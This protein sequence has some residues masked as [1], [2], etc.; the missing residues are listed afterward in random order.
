MGS[1]SIQKNEQ[2]NFVL[3]LAG[4][5]ISVLMSSVY[6]F[7]IGLFVLKMTGSG[8]SF[9]ITL[10]L[11]IIPTVLIGPLA[12]V[13]ADK[14]NKKIMVLL[15][16]AFNGALFIVMFFASVRGLSLW[17]IYTA[18]LL[19]S[20]SQTLY[21]VCIDSAVPDIVSERNIM[22]LNS[23]GKIIDA[24]A[25]IVSPGL[26][27]ILFTAIDIRYFFLLNGFAFILSTGTECLI[28]FRLFINPV[29][30]DR[31]FNLRKDLTEG[32]SY[33]R[34]TDWL[35]NTL[36]NFLII[37]FFIALCYSV[38]IPYILNSIFHLPAKAYGIVQCF[39]PVGMIIGALLIKKISVIISNSKL[40]LI[41]G[42]LFSL[43]LFLFGLLPAFDIHLTE[44]F[45][46]L[47]YAFLMACSGMIVSLIDIPFINNLQTRVPENIRGRSLSI[48]ISAVKIFTPVGYILSGCIIGI[49]PAFY[50]PLCGG[51]FLLIVYFIRLHI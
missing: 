51:G 35:R 7:A 47:Y 13:L 6:T 12:G 10:S 2:F 41:N 37:N 16:D 1:M 42:I 49:V 48:S 31:K 40:L 39:T 11:Q 14:F 3:F 22:K 45:I 24:A 44:T 50:L 9:A 25:A 38:P 8:L 30:Q 36:L 21:N 29:P 4:R 27:G 15:T 33:I 26:G 17:N 34:E 18:T 20:V 19:L 28:D 46:I 23:A 43:C 32:F 5:N